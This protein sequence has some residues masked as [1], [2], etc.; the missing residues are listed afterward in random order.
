MSKAIVSGGNGPGYGCMWCRIR[1]RRLALEL[2]IGGKFISAYS[3]MWN[4]VHDKENNLEPNPDDN[5]YGSPYDQNDERGCKAKVG[6]A[7]I[8]MKTIC[9]VK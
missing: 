7:T 6:A 4:A 8:F 1:L 3:R 2:M 9:W 5:C